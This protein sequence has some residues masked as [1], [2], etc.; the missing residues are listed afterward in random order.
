MVKSKATAIVELI[1]EE[2]LSGS[3]FVRTEP[4]SWHEDNGWFL[5][6]IN[7]QA[8]VGWQGSFL[9][10]GATDWFFLAIQKCVPEAYTGDLTDRL[11]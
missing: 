8:P 3:G 11:P 2:T 4:R 7:F 9:N 5:S 10:V 6:N 1:S